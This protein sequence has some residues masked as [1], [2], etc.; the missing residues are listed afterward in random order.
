MPALSQQRAPNPMTG[1]GL[2]VTGTYVC[3][4]YRL[5]KRIVEDYQRNITPESLFLPPNIN[6]TCD[7]IDRVAVIAGISPGA[8][9]LVSPKTFTRF[10]HLQFGTQ[11]PTQRNRCRS[12]S[13]TALTC[14]HRVIVVTSSAPALVSPRSSVDNERSVPPGSDRNRNYPDHYHRCCSTSAAWLSANVRLRPNYDATR[15]AISF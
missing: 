9:I 7:S 8:L 12:D 11:R 15:S 14:L 10:H 4:T 5:P 1:S 2:V 3:Q 13:S 6:S